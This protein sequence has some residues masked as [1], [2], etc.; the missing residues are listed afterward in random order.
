MHAILCSVHND[1]P[2]VVIPWWRIEKLLN[3]GM[4]RTDIGNI[5]I[6][7]GK[8]KAMRDGAPKDLLITV[9]R[10]KVQFLARVEH[11]FHVIKNLFGHREVCYIGMFK[12]AA[13]LF[14]LFGLANLVLARK[15]LLAPQGRNSSRARKVRRKGAKR[16]KCRPD[17]AFFSQIT[18]AKAGLTC[19]AARRPHRPAFPQLS[20]GRPMRFV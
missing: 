3:S 16:G 7:R 18:K 13:Q 10:T 15:R 8:I 17:L 19:V 4:I 9:E 11:P 12:E 14:S 1:A 20:R 2:E 5:P 6:R